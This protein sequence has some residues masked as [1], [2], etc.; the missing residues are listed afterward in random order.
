MRMY[1]HSW[2]NINALCGYHNF[3]F[4][5]MLKRDPG[6]DKQRG[7]IPPLIPCSAG[8]PS[9]GSRRQKRRQREDNTAAGTVPTRPAAQLGKFF[10]CV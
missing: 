9:L 1:T 8:V 4:P 6:I 7:G 10:M 3:S 2:I 5:E